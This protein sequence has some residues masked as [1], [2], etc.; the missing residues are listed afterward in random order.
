MNTTRQSDPGKLLS[1]PGEPEKAVGNEIQRLDAGLNPAMQETL[2]RKPAVPA[3]NEIERLAAGLAADHDKTSPRRRRTS[4]KRTAQPRPTGKTTGLFVALLV[5]LVWLPIPLGSNRSWAWAIME[6]WVCLMGAAWLFKYARGRV[7]LTASFKRARPA[8]ML[9]GVW[10]GY[11]LVQMV[12]LPGGLVA[13]LSPHAAVLYQQAGL[14]PSLDEQVLAPNPV[15]RPLPTI[16]ADPATSAG[17]VAAAVGGATGGPGVST[18]VDATVA[19]AAGAYRARLTLDLSASVTRWLQ[20]LA[21]VLLFALTLLLVDSPKRLKTLAT[22]IILSGLVQAVYGALSL[23]IAGG[24]VANGSFV[25]RNHYAAYLVLG[26]ALGIGLLVASMGQRHAA[27]TWRE[28]LRRIGGIILSGRAPLRLFLAIM[29][30]ALVLTHSRMGNVSFFASLLIAGGLA[31]VLQ[32]QMPRRIMLLIASLIVI[33][34]LII[35]S[36]VGIDKVR[37]RLVETTLETEMRDETGQHGLRLWQDYWL[38]GSGGGSFES[39]YPRYRQGDIGKG[40]LQHAHNDYLE[41]A[42]EYGVLGVVLPGGVV[43]LAIGQAVLAQRK[44]RNQLARGM[45]LAVLMAISAM[46][47]HAT[48]EFNLQIPAYA[49]TFMVILAMAWLARHLRSDNR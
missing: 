36:Y 44:R 29:V 27:L 12:P 25:N 7:P 49:A 48:V 46:L 40:V 41:F 6:V 24:G 45:G 37:D 8:L 28:R 9:L 38:L 39:V 15:E 31:L 22:V 43:I 1:F 35:G 21:Y 17:S 11:G 20:T 10:L 2:P 18:T 13:A 33:D 26:L 4:G 42:A 5:L 16:P 3:G 34:V 23:A 30:I 19:A 32:R 14:G 47:I